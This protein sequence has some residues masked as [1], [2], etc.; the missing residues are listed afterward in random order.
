[1]ASV[2]SYTQGG[3][4]GAILGMP[5]GVSFGMESGASGC[6][7]SS[8]CRSS[9]V[10]VDWVATIQSMDANAWTKNLLTSLH[11][12]PT[13]V[14]RHDRGRNGACALG[15]GADAVRAVHV[16]GS[17]QSDPSQRDSTL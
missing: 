16:S 2:S 9:M 1:M 10:R 15:Y 5:A 3:S 14:Q 13:Y 7:G 17:K 11:C 12:Y 8:V 6:A 4:P